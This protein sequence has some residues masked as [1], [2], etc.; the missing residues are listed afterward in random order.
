MIYL[1][2]AATT[3]LSSNMKKYLTS[4]LDIFGNP[5]SAHSE[6]VKANRLIE[7]VREKVAGFINADSR[8]N[9]YFT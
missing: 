1:D 3:E 2:N 6:G 4:V 5:S 9:I 8:D 7:E